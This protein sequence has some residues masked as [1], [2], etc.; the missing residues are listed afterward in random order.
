[1]VDYGPNG[2]TFHHNYNLTYSTFNSGLSCPRSHSNVLSGL[3]DVSGTADNI[4]ESYPPSAYLL[5]PQKPQDLTELSDQCLNSPC[6]QRVVKNEGFQQYDSQ[7]PDPQT[8]SYSLL[9]FL[10]SEEPSM[11]PNGSRGGEHANEENADMKEQPY[12]QLIY[13][14]LMEAPGH[15]MILRDIYEWFKEHTD[16]AADKETKGWQNSIRHN[17]SMNGAFEKVD[18]PCEDSKKGFMWRL[19]DKA[20]REGVK[21]T[22][23]YRSKLP[24]KRGHRS[25]NPAP[26]RQ[27]S[28]AKGGHAARKTARLRR[29][30]RLREGRGLG[31]H[32]YDQYIARSVPAYNSVPTYDSVFE[33]PPQADM[34][35]S[36]Y[37]PSP[38][39]TS[40]ANFSQTNKQ[41]ELSAAWSSNPYLLSEGTNTTSPQHTF[42]PDQAYILPCSPSEPLFYSDSSP[43]DSTSC[44]EPMT[45]S[46]ANGD[47]YVDPNM[48]V[49]EDYT[50]DEMAPNYT[51]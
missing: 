9:P 41:D 13:R 22:T 12:A 48:Q 20:I 51:H 44:D 16:K 31:G 21:S 49:P 32:R 26:Q 2:L 38:Y 27:A 33:P 14:A 7:N 29:S 6:L 39:S 50:L 19:T 47:F 28:G 17:L 23:R 45:P 35:F 36:S 40:E 5:E 11:P 30:G 25:H 4:T 8:I 46:D 3:G 43:A 15:T 34:C 10:K 24:N 42:Y 1:M 37:P 18:Q